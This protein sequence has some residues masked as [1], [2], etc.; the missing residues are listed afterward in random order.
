MDTAT[1]EKLVSELRAVVRDAEELLQ[2]AVS[3]SGA[4]DAL[5]DIDAQVR[6]HPWAAV[7]VAAGVG[8]LIALL[9]TRK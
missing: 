8:L 9:L 2:T 3:E 6:K 7:G 5:K 4:R 1:T